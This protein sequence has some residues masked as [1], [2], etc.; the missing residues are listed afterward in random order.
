MGVLLT[1]LGLFPCIGKQ[2][3]AL[4]VAA[5]E[6]ERMVSCTWSC[7][8]GRSKLC[9][10]FNSQ[11]RCIFPVMAESQ[12]INQLSVSL[13]Y[14]MTVMSQDTDRGERPCTVEGDCWPAMH[15]GSSFAFYQRAK[16]C[17]NINAFFPPWAIDPWTFQAWRFSS[18]WTIISRKSGGHLASLSYGHGA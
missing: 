4:G 5:E 16:Y 12:A 18:S 1:S 9:V 11:P 2:I 8:G 15:K 6:H 14:S 7:A 3:L 17:T 10:A 13:L